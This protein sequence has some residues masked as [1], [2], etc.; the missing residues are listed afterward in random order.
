MSQYFPKPDE[1]F[2]GDV[3]VR[4]DFRATKSASTAIES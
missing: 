2:G 3:N 1:I 4:V